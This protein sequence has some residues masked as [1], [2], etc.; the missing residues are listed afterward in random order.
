M[1][2]CRSR[3]KLAT[4]FQNLHHCGP[5]WSHCGPTFNRFHCSYTLHACWVR[6]GFVAQQSSRARDMCYHVPPPSSH[7][8]QIP[9]LQD[10]D[11][12]TNSQHTEG[13][14]PVW[15]A[16]LV[17]NY[18]KQDGCFAVKVFFFQ[19]TL[20]RSSQM[21][22]I[23]FEIPTPWRGRNRIEMGGSVHKFVFLNIWCSWSFGSLHSYIFHSTAQHRNN[24]CH[25]NK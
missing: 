3:H 12:S 24:E 23:H 11:D 10:N 2:T 7:P 16:S 17:P 8:R 9:W 20:R 5:S 22:K 25:Y 14:Q 21:A 1:A 19:L 15:S 18:W 6:V 4:Q 13:G